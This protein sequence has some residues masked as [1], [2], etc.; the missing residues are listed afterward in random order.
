[1]YSLTDKYSL[2][3]LKGYNILLCFTFHFTSVYSPTKLVLFEVLYELRWELGSLIRYATTYFCILFNMQD[4]YMY[5]PEEG[6]QGCS[7]SHITR[8]I[9]FTLTIVLET[10]R[11][12]GALA[13]VMN[14]QNAVWT[15]RSNITA[16]NNNSTVSHLCEI[17]FKG[18]P[19]YRLYLRAC[20]WQLQLGRNRTQ[21]TEGK[22]KKISCRYTQLIN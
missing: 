16:C 3:L 13:L 15:Q 9:I 18:L 12:K 10:Q 4:S 2:Y 1:M 6:M 17:Y 8:S 22:E 19:K 14:W 11:S 7:L 21:I 5:I 20:I